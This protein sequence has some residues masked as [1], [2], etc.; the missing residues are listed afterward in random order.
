MLP[1]SHTDVMP[2]CS[3][4]V[5]HLQLAE[6]QEEDLEWHR[7]R[8]DRAREAVSQQRQ[9]EGERAAL[10]KWLPH[11]FVLALMC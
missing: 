11:D 8:E 3:L 6:D 9:L 2:L 4:Y 5:T 10:R 1:V 7:T